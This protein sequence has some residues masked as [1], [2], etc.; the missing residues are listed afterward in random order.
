M[1]ENTT[2]ISAIIFIL[3]VIFVALLFIT[4]NS[5]SLNPE[6]AENTISILVSILPQK[7][8][9]KKV[10]EGELEAQNIQVHALIK[11]GESP[12]TYSLTASDLQVIE[13]ADIYY[14]IGYIEFE[15]A[16]LERIKETNPNLK[17]ID[18]PE[19]IALRH[20][21][22]KESHS[23]D[24]DGHDDHEEES[25]IDPHLW[26]SIPNVKL[27][28]D[29]IAI[30]LSAIDT[31]NS[32]KYF[33]NA[34]SYKKELDEVD[35]QISKELEDFASD[36]MLVFHPAWGYF[37]DQYGLSQV[38]IEYQGNDPTANQLQEIITFA[39]EEQVKA[40]F[41]QEQ[42][43]TQAAQSIASELNIAVIKIDPL[44]ENYLENLKSISK[45]IKNNL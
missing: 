28:V 14:P 33:D 37:T 25:S 21:D 13:N 9:V 10:A 4:Q 8:F 24:H 42:F 30:E 22:D 11:P 41:V 35:S 38:A 16:N 32:Q 45:S 6:Q 3:M 40:V 39:K 17:V 1:K 34:K 29:S 27:L 7:E 20:F 26:L 12:A 23:H 18:I 44:A 36:P 43:S 31:Q 15:K 5:K 2:K 19:E